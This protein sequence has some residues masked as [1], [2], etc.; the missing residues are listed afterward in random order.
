[1]CNWLQASCLVLPFFS[2]TVLLPPAPIA[3]TIKLDQ[4]DVIFE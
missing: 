1:M 3:Y 4:M 2:I